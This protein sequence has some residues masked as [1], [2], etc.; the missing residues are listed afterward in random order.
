MPTC[1]KWPVLVTFMFVLGLLTLLG[2]CQDRHSQVIDSVN[3]RIQVAMS[4]YID[5]R[6]VDGV[7]RHYDPVEG[8]LLKMKFA[9]LHTGVKKKG[10]FHV[11]CA[12]FVDQFQRKLDVD[13][14]VLQDGDSVLVTQAL[15]HKIDG[16]KRKYELAGQ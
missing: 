4:K 12:D 10:D 13:Y 11:S 9:G 7:Y 2:G 1:N 6:T 15:L 8:K 14:F 3:D 16:Q 5:D